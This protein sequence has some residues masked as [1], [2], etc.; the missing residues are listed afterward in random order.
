MSTENTGKKKK[1]KLR[2]LLILSSHSYSRSRRRLPGYY[3]FSAYSH[4]EKIRRTV[5]FR[6]T[7]NGLFSY[8]KSP[9]EPGSFRTLNAVDLRNAVYMDFFRELNR[10]MSFEISGTI[11]I[12]P[13]TPQDNCP[14][15]NMYR[16]SQKFTRKRSANFSV[17][18]YLPLFLRNPCLLTRHTKNLLLL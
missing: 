4:A 12:F 17:R 15:L 8:G 14:I 10:Q 9:A 16:R 2:L 1:T 6:R 13:D 7:E 3:Y 18:W 5:P 11:L